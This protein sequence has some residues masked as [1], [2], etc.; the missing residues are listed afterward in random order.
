MGLQVLGTWGDGSQ[1]G[2]RETLSVGFPGNGDHE[3][4]QSDHTSHRL[5]IQKLSA[6][7]GIKSKLLVTAC[8]TLK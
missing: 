7:L 3:G 8:K 4:E 5:S 2:R 1:A 6:V